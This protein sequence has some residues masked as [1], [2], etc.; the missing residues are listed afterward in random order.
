MDQL[1]HGRLNCEFEVASIK[2]LPLP[3]PV[4]RELKK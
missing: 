2:Y 3:E 1:R 4:V